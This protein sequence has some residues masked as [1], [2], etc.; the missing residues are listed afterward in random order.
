MEHVT[1]FHSE[2]SSDKI[3]RLFNYTPRLKRLSVKVMNLPNNNYITSSHPKLI[4]LNMHFPYSINVSTIPDFLKSMPNLRHLEINLRHNLINGHQWE[5]IIRNY[6]PKL[7]TFRLEMR[8]VPRGNQIIQEQADNLFDSFR[9]S[10]WIDEK[11]WFVRC[12]IG[13]GV[14]SLNTLSNKP[15]EYEEIISGLH[16]YTCS[17][18]DYRKYYS[19]MTTID[20]ITFFNHPIPSNIRLSNITYLC[21]KLPVNDQFWSIVPNLNKL[22]TL[23]L[24]SYD[25]TME[26]ELQAILDRAPYLTILTIHQDAS[27]SIQMSLFKYTNPSIR[28]LDLT[29]YVHYFNEK[30]C[31]LLSH[32][33]LGIQCEVLSIRI[34]NRENIITLVKNMINLRILRIYRSDEEDSDH[35]YLKRNNDR[36]FLKGDNINSNELIQ[37]L[38]DQLPS[39]CVV[40]KDLHYVHN[41]LIWI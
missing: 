34:N 27:L 5:H 30:E 25:D 33:S 8:C 40:V 39:T 7:K 16:K 38:K 2:L 3:K 4:Q 37:W 18:D 17:D 11:Q 1:I 29:N 14:I 19:C 32:S 10:F 28:E 13:K 12:F 6:L 22:K 36:P 41:I 20:D 31:L 21:I 35:I 26:S 9:N 24:S 15:D 23:V